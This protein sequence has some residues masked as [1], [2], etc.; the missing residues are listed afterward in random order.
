MERVEFA[1]GKTER[2]RKKSSAMQVEVL[3]LSARGA[4]AFCVCEGIKSKRELKVREEIIIKVFTFCIC[5]ASFAPSSTPPPWPKGDVEEG[6]LLE[7]I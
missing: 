5:R 6:L 7:S 1:R 4:R 2:N 3:M